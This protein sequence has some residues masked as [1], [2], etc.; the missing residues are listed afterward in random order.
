MVKTVGASEQREVLNKL[1]SFKVKL[2]NYRLNRLA[3]HKL[4]MPIDYVALNPYQLW[5]H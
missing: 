5:P 3:K 1:F 2:L 4:F